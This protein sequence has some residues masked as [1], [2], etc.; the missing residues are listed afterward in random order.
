MIFGERLKDFFLKDQPSWVPRILKKVYD[1]CL[2]LYAKTFSLCPKVDAVYLTGS[3]AF[4][5]GH[6]GSSDLDTVVFMALDAKPLHVK[7]VRFL[8]RLWSL[9]PLF[10]V[11]CRPLL[12]KDYHELLEVN[13]LLKLRIAVERS[14]YVLLTG[15][16]ILH[17]PHY[18]VQITGD[19][20][21]VIMTTLRHFWKEYWSLLNKQTSLFELK[22]HE[23][24]RVLSRLEDLHRWLQG[25]SEKK[26]AL[27][28]PL[29]STL[30]QY[31]QHYGILLEKIINHLDKTSEQHQRNIQ[32]GDLSH[33]L[34][35]ELKKYHLKNFWLTAPLY[36]HMDEV[37]LYVQLDFPDIELLKKIEK[38]IKALY[39]KLTFYLYLTFSECAL[40]M[41]QELG[42]NDEKY[43]VDSTVEPLTSGSFF[44]SMVH[45]KRV[46]QTIVQLRDELRELYK[47]GIANGDLFLL[48]T[49][50]IQSFT[51]KA[52]QFVAL[53]EEL[54]SSSK[55][56][57]VPIGQEEI[58]NSLLEQCP[59]TKN[60][61]DDQFLP[62]AVNFLKEYVT[63]L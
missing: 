60:W 54:L 7:W 25:N 30:N 33:P 3:F 20:R 45:E 10:D 2:F 53:R 12:H 42:K 14:G 43:I 17:G 29:R 34:K 51:W 52:L 40:L 16:D 8:H 57:Y 44:T 49:I 41:N 26:R 32:W 4:G 28:I 18:Q 22:R 48:P 46:Q 1:T 21:Y 58:R 63:R 61:I 23:L 11:S 59:E 6:Y 31:L 9:L 50:K 37:C 47:T 62:G 39:P 5:R 27:P 38:D 19:S 35:E 24:N 55:E 56:I 13:I 36:G 15:K